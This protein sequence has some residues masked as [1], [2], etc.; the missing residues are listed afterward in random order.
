MANVS[1]TNYWQGKPKGA[2]NQSQKNSNRELRGRLKNLGARNTNHNKFLQA[3][4]PQK[5]KG[6]CDRRQSVGWWTTV[7]I[8]FL[9]LTLLLGI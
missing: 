3:Q 1:Q 4:L 5:K 8:S 6:W 9:Y 2:L 7:G